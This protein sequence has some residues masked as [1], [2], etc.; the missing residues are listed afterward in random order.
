MLF[1]QAIYTTII[2]LISF[3]RIAAQEQ[4]A[5]ITSFLENLDKKEYTLALGNTSA[6]FRAAVDEN[7]LATLW[8]QLNG[9]FGSYESFRQ[10]DSVQQ[11][12]TTLVS[13]IFEK[14]TVP[15][16]F[17]FD[18][19]K[20]IQGFFIKGAP[21]ARA[22]AQN[23]STIGE[24]EI[25]IRV[26]GGVISGSLLLPQQK[27][28]EM[29]L[30]I[31]IA[32]SGPTDRN[33]NNPY[34]VS[35]NPYGL[36]AQALAKAGIA[37]YRYDKRLV[38]QSSNFNASSKELVFNDFA[39]DAAYITQFFRSKSEYGKIIL[40]GHSEGSNIGMMA[41]Q[42]TAPDA[43]ISLS[44]AGENL[45]DIIGKQ[46]IAQPELA[47]KA[48]PI[49]AKLKQGERVNQIPSELNALFDTSV[50]PFLITSF[51]INPAEEIKKLSIPLLIV[52]GTTDLQVPI[53]NAEKLKASAPEAQLLLIK[54]MN[55]VLKTA[56]NDTTGNI[57]TYTN[58]D[59]PIH[60][61]LVVG[62]V[63]FINTLK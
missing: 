29:P 19:N 8:Q 51:K 2:F 28:E 21:E 46:L 63:Q 36:L 48:E 13:L 52:G 35:A 47:Q 58:P 54:G 9:Q 3:S 27:R 26:N 56:P 4:I 1:K 44:G 18:E 14:Y 43:L 17:S 16:S 33:G 11:V 10:N 42:K 24:E 6:N 41:A 53:D 31:M 20:L 40:I 50:Q 34:G 5:R 49:L 60:P 62:I 15:V 55:H 61:D 39:E 22:V 12:N 25:N 45:A 7:K 59:L 32:G 38:G 57:G 37:S 30:A 23:N